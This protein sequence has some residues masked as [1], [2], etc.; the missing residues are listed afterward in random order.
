[1]SAK[2]HHR[3]YS[4]QDS[5]EKIL[6]WPQAA[7]PSFVPYK[8]ISQHLALLPMSPLTLR[9][10]SSSH[11]PTL[12]LL[13]TPGPL[14]GTPVPPFASGQNLPVLWSC[15]QQSRHSLPDGV[16][17]PF[18]T[19]HSAS[20]LPFPARITAVSAHCFLGLSDQ[21]LPS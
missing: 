12:M 9:G 5:K 1:M 20:H 21:C 16:K 19:S 14:P 18:K 3:L 13:H 7:S 17:I 10:C 15:M 4:L 6:Q 11:T 8:L 2:A